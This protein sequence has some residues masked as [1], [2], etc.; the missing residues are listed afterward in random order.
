MAVQAFAK[1]VG[2][3]WE[4]YMTKPKIVLG[5]GG[6]GVEVDVIV[7]SKTVV[8][9][10]HFTIRFAPEINA[11]EV[12]SLSKNGVLVNGELLRRLARPAVI[13]SQTDIAFGNGEEMHVSILLPAWIKTSR[14]K[15]GRATEEKTPLL[16]WIGEAL[17]LGHMLSAEQLRPAIERAHPGELE[18][19]G[20]R[21]VVA[22]SIRHVLTQNDHIF[23]V[24]ESEIVEKT[25]NHHSDLA[26]NGEVDAALF[27]VREEHCT[28]FLGSSANRKRIT[29]DTQG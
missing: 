21:D 4:H 12:E 20:S 11:F 23:Q 10:R 19:L 22:S 18:K 28:K 7:S 6:E 8:S 24:V 15:R 2:V 16:E 5:R 27:A 26:A 1:L 17:V 13:R 29:S 14:K 9:R 25:W 3:G